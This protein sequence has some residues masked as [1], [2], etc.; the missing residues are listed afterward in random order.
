MII[1][2]RSIQCHKSYPI[3]LW[4]LVPVIIAGVNMNNESYYPCR[5]KSL[6]ET[7]ATVYMSTQGIPQG[8]PLAPLMVTFTLSFWV[9]SVLGTSGQLYCG[10]KLVMAWCIFNGFLWEWGTEDIHTV[11]GIMLAF[12]LLY[13][14]NS[15]INMS[16]WYV[17]NFNPRH[18]RLNKHSSAKI[19]V[20]QHNYW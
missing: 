1:K 13:F 16:L 20:S 15:D 4:A 6:G 3:P 19:S 8:G 11:V 5:T 17:F 18:H 9:R 12:Y 7:Q 2:P 14:I 10:D